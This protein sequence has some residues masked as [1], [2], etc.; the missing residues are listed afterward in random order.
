KISIIKKQGNDP[1]IHDKNGLRFHLG[2]H[3][4]LLVEHAPGTSFDDAGEPNPSD[5]VLYLDGRSL[6]G[7]Y[8]K[9]MRSESE[10][11][12]EEEDQVT[13][14]VLRY[15]LTRDLSTPEGRRN[16]T[17]I[18]TGPKFGKIMNVSTG[19]EHGEAVPTDAQIS[20]V[21]LTGTRVAVALLVAVALAIVFMVLLLKTG[22]LRDKEPAGPEIREPTQRAYSL[23]RV[24]ALLWTL[25]TV[26]AF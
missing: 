12:T 5:L 24:Q 25:L 22:A 8:A 10:D 26:Y 16:W 4:N 7:T 23:S 20:L 9:V 11:E 2:D 3:I 6:P 14:T 19:L 21:V 18:V 13:W 15:E 1:C 17:Q